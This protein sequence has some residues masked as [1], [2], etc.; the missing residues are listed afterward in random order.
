[1][2]SPTYVNETATINTTASSTLT[3][4]V[5]G[6]IA[7]GDVILL[8]V[9]SDGAS[10]PV[11]SWPSGFTQGGTGSTNNQTGSWAW[12]AAA[13]ESGSY[14]VTQTFTLRG[15]IICVA[16]RGCAGS[17]INASSSAASSAANSMPATVTAPSVT[18][19]VANT[20]LVWCGMNDDGGGATGYTAPSGYTKCYDTGSTMDATQA[21]CDIANA[22]AGATGSVSGTATGSGT[23]GWIS[24]LIALAPLPTGS[25]KQL[26]TLGV[27]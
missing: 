10:N 25:T 24:F 27:G 9:N 19:T 4:S 5:P 3:V 8:F 7:N 22:S 6:S 15:S 21:V 14:V 18:T 11:T 13:S 23:M 2:A 12:K 20:T 17:P 16:Y 1:M 26:L